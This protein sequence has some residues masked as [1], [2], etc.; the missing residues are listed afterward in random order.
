MKK[1]S[2]NMFERFKDAI[3]VLIRTKLCVNTH[4]YSRKYM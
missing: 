2:L 3:G 1:A 4:S